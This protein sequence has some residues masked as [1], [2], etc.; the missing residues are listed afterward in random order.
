[1]EL[2]CHEIG[3]IFYKLLRVIIFQLSIGM[4]NQKR[5]FTLRR[6]NGYTLATPGGAG[7][8]SHFSQNCA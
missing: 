7:I 8:H 6:P 3:G 1:M 2:L 5:H 4:N